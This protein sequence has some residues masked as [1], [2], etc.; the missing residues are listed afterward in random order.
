MGG[1][2]AVAWTD[3]IQGLIMVV[4]L[5]VLALAAMGELGGCLDFPFETVGTPAEI[6][7]YKSRLQERLQ[8]CGQPVPQYR[9]VSESGPDHDKTFTVEITLQ[10]LNAIGTGRNKKAAEQQAAREALKRLADHD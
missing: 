8:T 4:G 7:D 5:V 1:F 6:A 10:G 9:V 3:F 2:L